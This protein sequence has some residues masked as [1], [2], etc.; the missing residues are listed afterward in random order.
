[1]PPWTLSALGGAASIAVYYVL[2]R[3][4]SGRIE[5][6]LGALIV[7]AAATIGV[8][9][10]LVFGMRGDVVPTSRA[11]VWF[12]VGSGLGVAVGSVMLF[13]ALRKGGPVASVGIIVL[14]GGVA[15][16]AMLAPWLF[17]E[18]FTLRRAIGVILGLA[19]MWVLG[20]E[21]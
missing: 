7:E 21:S 15:L 13:A 2:L 5:D 12:S 6:R 10:S 14:G 17:G 20:S 19:A 11:G 8:A 3:A 16:S 1:M 9:A 4:A 18:S